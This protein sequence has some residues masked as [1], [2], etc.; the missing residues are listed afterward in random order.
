MFFY[1]MYLWELIDCVHVGN[2]GGS[3]YDDM[4]VGVQPTENNFQTLFKGENQRLRTPDINQLRQ[5]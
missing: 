4:L 1:H 5:I 3:I 2:L